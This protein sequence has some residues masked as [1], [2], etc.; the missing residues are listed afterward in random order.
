MAMKQ[1][2]VIG[3]GAFG[4]TML[5]KIAEVTD[6]I[7]AADPDPVRIEKIKELVLTAFVFD[8]LDE[9]AF[10][11]VFQEPVDVAVV[12]IEMQSEATLLVVHRLKKLGV[13]EIIARSD[14]EEYEELLRL[15]GATRVVNAAKEA[16]SRIAPLVLSRSLLNYMP[17]SEHLVM[18]EVML[19]SFLVGRTVIEANLRSRYHVNVVAVRPSDNAPAGDEDKNGVFIDITTDYRFKVGDVLLVTG[20]ESDVFAFSGKAGEHERR[21]GKGKSLASVMTQLFT[22]KAFHNSSKKR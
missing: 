22:I 6:Q 4:M 17:I 15:A 7:L 16:A 19:P 3:L 11:R 20:S 8:P 10:H 2:A 9:E 18:A 12:D 1:Y 5:E 14:S 13:P 21:P